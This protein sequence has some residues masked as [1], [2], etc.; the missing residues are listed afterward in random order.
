MWR[1]TIT[2]LLLASALLTAPPVRAQEALPP[3]WDKADPEDSAPAEEPEP[4]ADESDFEDGA[5]FFDLD[6][7]YHL[8]HRQLELRVGAGVR[9][10]DEVSGDL[11]FDLDFRWG[12]SEHV[13]IF[14]LGA[15]GRIDSER[16]AYT[17][18]GGGIKSIGYSDVD[19]FAIEPAVVVTHTEPIGADARF[20]M[21]ARLGV[22]VVGGDLGDVT[23]VAATAF[24]WRPTERLMLSLGVGYRYRHPGRQ[25]RASLSTEPAYAGT[26]DQHEL[27][28][29]AS[30]GRP[31]APH[32]I[33][34]VRIIG[35]LSAYAWSVVSVRTRPFGLAGHTHVGGL[36]LSF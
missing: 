7:T 30:T 16:G 8:P 27:L 18:L 13:M 36:S 26:D 5:I 19:G 1:H 2:L 35:G 25:F 24:T 10:D 29:G 14:L 9:Y 34:S 31:Y 23:A 20:A 11:Q 3:D 6:R 17:S 4:D 28:F 33:V 12:V 22:A 15:M 32:P 21:Q